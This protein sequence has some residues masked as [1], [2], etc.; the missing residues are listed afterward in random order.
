MAC[1]LMPQT[2]DGISVLKCAVERY[3]P[4]PSTL[5]ALHADL[6]QVSPG[7]SPSLCCWSLLSVSSSSLALS[8]GQVSEASQTLPGTRIH[9]TA[10]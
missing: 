5:T 9:S 1:L 10:D 8:Y 6:I 3:Q 4:N 2:L 7:P